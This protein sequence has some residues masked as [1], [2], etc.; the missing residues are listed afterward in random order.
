MVHKP[1][2]QTVGGYREEDHEFKAMMLSSL[3]SLKLA[4]STWDPNLHNQQEN[5]K[6]K[7]ILKKREWNPEKIW[8]SLRCKTVYTVQTDFVQPAF[9]NTEGSSSKYPPK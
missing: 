9:P 5:Q 3:L 6:A 4:W 2:I 8:F 1:V 7:I